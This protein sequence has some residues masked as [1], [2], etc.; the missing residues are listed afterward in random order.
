MSE[1]WR[2]NCFVFQEF[3]K[4][5]EIV[6]GKDQQSKVIGKTDGWF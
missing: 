2:F 5:Y 6:E 3:F 1:A 4:T